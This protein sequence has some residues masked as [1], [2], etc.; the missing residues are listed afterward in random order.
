MKRV[1]LCSGILLAILILSISIIFTLRNGNKKICYYIDNALA[2]AEAD[3]TD[4]AL[5]AIDEL[6]V[7]WEKYYVMTSYFIQ[8]SKLED[9]NF[10]V[11]K[12]RPLLEKDSEEFYSE[13]MVIRYG[14]DKL[15]KNELPTPH[16]II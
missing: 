8:S 9:I 15:Y 7:Y 5:M 3:R 11:S 10:S 14:L 2:L 6:G 16:S 1:A 13:C 4:R 12:L